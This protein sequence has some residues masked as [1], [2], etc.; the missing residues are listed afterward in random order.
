MNGQQKRKYLNATKIICKVKNGIRSKDFAE[1]E[2]FFQNG[3]FMQNVQSKATTAFTATTH[4]HTQIHARTK[5][6]Q[7][8]LILTGNFVRIVHEQRFWQTDDIKSI[9]NLCDNNILFKK[10]KFS[11]I[12]HVSKKCGKQ[13]K[14]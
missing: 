8:A 12:F 1:D 14:K 13:F 11:F 9:R 6:T 4:R 3:N 10:Q 5:N 7:I 2:H